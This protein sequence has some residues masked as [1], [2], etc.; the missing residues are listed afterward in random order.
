MGFILV[1]NINMVVNMKKKY[2]KGGKARSCYGWCKHLRK[3]GK[4]LANK[5]TRKEGKHE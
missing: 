1:Q 2:G 5:A 4:R 3:Y